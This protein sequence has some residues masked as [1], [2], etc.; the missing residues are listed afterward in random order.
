MRS[1]RGTSYTLTMATSNYFLR[2]DLRFRQGPSPSGP[3]NPNTSRRTEDS[4][5]DFLEQFISDNASAIFGLLG[6]LAGGTVSFL[7]SWLLRKREYDLRL[8]DRL[9]ERR[10]TAHESLIAMALEMRVMAA[11]GAVEKDG[12]VARA[13]HVLRSRDDFEQWFGRFTQITMQGTTWL[14]TD[15]KR[16]L[17][18]VQDYLVTLYQS[19]IGVPSE[20]YL[21][22]GQVIRQDFIDLSSGLEKKAYS[23]FGREVRRLKLSNLTD[24]HKYEPSVTEARLK[25][26]VLLSQWQRIN[27]IIS[28][29]QQGDSE[30][31]HP[32]GTGDSG[33]ATKA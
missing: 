9:L 30:V 29:G 27:S 13:P 10:I 16:E 19:L 31:R 23:F 24:W 32:D 21:L 18:F 7:A 11:L 6:A 17:N 12:D 2:H 8:W 25:K 4:S 20:K 1:L 22:I 33:C 5:L 3:T 28:G 14:T 26:T 15:A